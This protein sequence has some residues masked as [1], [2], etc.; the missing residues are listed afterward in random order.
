[1]GGSGGLAGHQLSVLGGGLILS[2]GQPG[3][4]LNGLETEIWSDGTNTCQLNVDVSNVSFTSGC[5][6][7]DWGY[8]FDLLNANIVSGDCSPLNYNAGDASKRGRESYGIKNIDAQNAEL[9][10]FTGSSW[11]QVGTVFFGGDPTDACDFTWK[12]PDP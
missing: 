4:V 8:D 5:P 9:W 6:T 12:W 3:A 2:L 10:R 11:A 1:M 7:C